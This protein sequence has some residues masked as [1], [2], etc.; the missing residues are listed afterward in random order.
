MLSSSKSPLAAPVWQAAQLARLPIAAR[1]HTYGAIS[2]CLRS[3]QLDVVMRSC[4]G[5]S[6][7]RL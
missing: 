1:F 4:G 5:S 7:T 2:R 3:N 6:L